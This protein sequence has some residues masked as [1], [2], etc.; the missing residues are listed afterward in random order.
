[1]PRVTRSMYWTAIFA[2]A[3]PGVLVGAVAGH[4]DWFRPVAWSDHATAAGAYFA[5]TLAMLAVATVVDALNGPGD[6]RRTALALAGGRVGSDASS[7]D[8]PRRNDLGDRRRRLCRR[9]PRGMVDAGAV[10]TSSSRH[11]LLDRPDVASPGT[12]DGSVSA[13]FPV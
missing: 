5:T 12:P 3:T 11:R 2:A 9:Y 7:G 6:V 8:A 10:G 4:L 1:M 13:C